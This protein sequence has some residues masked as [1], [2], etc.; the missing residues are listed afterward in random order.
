[1]FSPFGSQNFVGLSV[2]DGYIACGSE[3]NEVCVKCWYQSRFLIFNLGCRVFLLIIFTA[4]HLVLGTYLG[5]FLSLHST[6]AW[7]QAI[8][9]FPTSDLD[10]G[11]II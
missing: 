6:C 5:S 9:A 4:M 8:Y 2:S 3:T 7:E 10:I 1:M 11:W